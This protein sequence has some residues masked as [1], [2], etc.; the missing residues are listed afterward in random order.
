MERVASGSRA[1]AN[2]L[3]PGDIITATSAGQVS[4]LSSLRSSLAD[5]P[6]QL[7]LLIERGNVRGR[8][9]LQ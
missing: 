3:R 5:T 6:R 8:L 7:V 4:D 9:V 2:G 1:E